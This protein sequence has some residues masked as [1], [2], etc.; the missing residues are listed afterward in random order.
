MPLKAKVL[1][2]KENSNSLFRRIRYWWYD[3]TR[4]T[5]WDKHIDNGIRDFIY[6]IKNIYKWRKIIW[7]DRDWSNDYIFTVLKFKIKNTRDYIKRNDIIID[8][9]IEVID[10]YCSI[11]INLI[12]K[13][14]EGIYSVEYLD[15]FETEFEFVEIDEIDEESG[16]KLYEM[17]SK[18][19]SSAPDPYF[20]K[21][22][23]TFKKIKRKYPDADDKILAMRIAD[24][25]EQK[26]LGLLFKILHYHIQ[27]WWD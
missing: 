17:K 1:N 20:S 23:N 3:K 24:D 19:L 5:F 6:G 13:I 7:K 21:Y 26:A 8:E 12:N 9:Q 18:L 10:R 25:I 15:Y 11:C 16:E 4:N 27:N 14:Q 22:K 2:Q